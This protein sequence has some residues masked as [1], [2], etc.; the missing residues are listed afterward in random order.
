MK[1]SVRTKFTLAA[2]FFFIVVAAIT[3]LAAYQF[4]QLSGK[5]KAILKENQYSV[6]CARQMADHLNTLNT[7]IA[8]N[9]VTE[10]EILK[11][12][13]NEGITGFMASL[14]N[15]KGNI[16]E[17][18]EAN[19]VNELEGAFKPYADS[20]TSLKLLPIKP[21]VKDYLIQQNTLIHN[22]LMQLSS[23]NENAIEYKTNDAKKTVN[24]SL[25][26]VSITASVGFL[27]A[28]SFAF[29]FAVYFN[30]RFSA[31]YK[32]LQQL[33]QNNY[34]ERLYFDG[35]DEFTEIGLIYNELTEKLYQEH[36]KNEV[37]SISKKHSESNA[38]LVAE[39][40]H[41]IAKMKLIEQQAITL[42][43]RLEN[44]TT[45]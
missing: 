14:N 29:N 5:T 31:L 36:E 8:Q 18:G 42:I 35:K 1:T 40:Q 28:L 41:T 34:R 15:E 23:I 7:A 2:A 12:Q 25:L 16:T 22:K 24:K 13:I 37:V 30:N 33:S 19:L 6:I 38:S 21:I 3:T 17:P 32:G 43:D 11:G 10:I 26:L 27:I 9:A 4:Y 20:L 39:L 45:L 44:K